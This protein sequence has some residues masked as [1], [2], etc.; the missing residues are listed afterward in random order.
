[1]RSSAVVL[2]LAAWATVLYHDPMSAQEPAC[3]LIC[4]PSFTFSPGVGVPRV[5][6]GD[7]VR[8]LPSNTE[9]SIDPRADL[10]LF[11]TMDMPTAIPRF[12]LVA[13]VGW[14]P[15]ADRTTN[16]FTGYTAT[17]QGRDNI[18][19][20]EL[21]I[22]LGGTVAL[23]RPQDTKGWFGL[24]VGAFD[25][26][27]AARQADDGRTYSHKLDLEINTSYGFFNWLPRGNY[28]RNVAGFADLVYL[29][30]GLP[31]RDDEVPSGQQVYLEHANGAA[32]FAGLTF[33]IAP[34]VPEK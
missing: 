9:T 31:S 32:F 21:E 8:L 33:P 22:E 2:S 11:L 20:N 1:M 6:S 25:Q 30:T 34:L 7:R 19:A 29:A 12:N 3:R 17:Q 24:K 5:F 4:A 10:F 23:I 28:L 15:T 27:G 14:S 16:P 26:I 13:Q 18:A